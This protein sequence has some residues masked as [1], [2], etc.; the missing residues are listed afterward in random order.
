M[1]CRI[2]IER[3]LLSCMHLFP[4]QVHDFQ[5]HYCVQGC[6]RWFQI[7]TSFSSDSASWSDDPGG[8]AVQ[9][10][11]HRPTESHLVIHESMWF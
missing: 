8:N 10:V 1:N 7:T 2:Y 11:E 3:D 5:S 4:F 6:L 9:V